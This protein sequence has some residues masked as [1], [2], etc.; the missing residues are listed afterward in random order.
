[1][2]DDR[3]YLLHMKECIE[4]IESYTIDGRDTFISSNIVQDA[5]LRNLHTLAESTQ[6]IS[7]NL[8]SAHP[9]IDWKGI[10]GFRNI[11]VHEYLGIDLTYCWKVVEHDLPPLKNAVCLMIEGRR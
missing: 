5:V 11:I 9:E 8:K 1:M 4:R 2:K 7:D 6:R 3:L 10:S